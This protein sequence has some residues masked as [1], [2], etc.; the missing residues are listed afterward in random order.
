[1]RRIVRLSELFNI[2]KSVIALFTRTNLHDIFNIVNKYLTVTDV[3][4]VKHLL[5][6][7]NHLRYGHLANDD[8]HLDFRQK[9]SFNRNAAIILLFALQYERNL[10]LSAIA[11]E[12]MVAVVAQNTRLNTK[13]EKLKSA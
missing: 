12:T 7:F 4:C 2:L 6:R 11:P 13:F 10:V 3:A 5:R 9:R 1:M 8:I